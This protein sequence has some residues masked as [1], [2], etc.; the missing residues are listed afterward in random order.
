[1]LERRNVLIGGAGADKMFGGLGDD[2]YYVDNA[3]D[4]VVESGDAT[5]GGT[6]TVNSTIS[7]TL[8]NYVEKLTLS[9]TTAINGT[10]NALANTIIGN[11]AA[12][13]LSGGDGADTL[14]GGLGKD[15]LEGGNGSDV[16]VFNAPSEAG[17]TS[18]TWDV[19]NDFA[20][21]QDKIDLRGID[22]NRAT[23][24]NDAFTTFIA[25]TAA[26]TAAG[27]L[28]FLNGVLYG[29]TDDDADAE[30][31]IQLTGVTQLTSADVVL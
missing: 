18:A 25:S 11:A 29:N 28:K 22:A 4:T 1:M 24:A 23:V 27:Q 6:D 15:V 30:F 13:V 10:G 8:G 3:G 16:F 9:G 7:Y 21:G 12:N 26:F 5:L 31:A 19:I 17:A 2:F 14:V 20:R